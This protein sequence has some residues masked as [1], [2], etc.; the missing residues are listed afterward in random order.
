MR[1]SLIFLSISCFVSYLLLYLFEAKYKRLE[2]EQK[3]QA[4]NEEETGMMASENIVSTN[5]NFAIDSR[6]RAQDNACS[7][8]DSDMSF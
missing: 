8:S 2:A 7:S 3:L 4:T 5:D 6:D 1:E